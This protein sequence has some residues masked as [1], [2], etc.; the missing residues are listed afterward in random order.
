MC[1]LVVGLARNVEVFAALWYSTPPVPPPATLVAVA[2][3]PPML[4]FATAVVLVTANGAVPVA[5]VEVNCPVADR[6]VNAPV[7]GVVPPI[8]PGLGNELV[9]LPK[10]TD[11]PPIVIAEFDSAALATVEQVGAAMPLMAVIT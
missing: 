10:E 4:R 8:A 6:V 9:E 2:A 7:D 5:R 11:V 1:P 3:V